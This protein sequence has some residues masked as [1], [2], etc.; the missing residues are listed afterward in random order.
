ME[1]TKFSVK[2]EKE[3]DEVGFNG[4]TLSNKKYTELMSDLFGP[5]FH[6]TF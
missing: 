5:S 4:P 6:P 3:S 2:E 1:K